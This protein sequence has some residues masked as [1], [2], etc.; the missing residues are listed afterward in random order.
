MEHREAP[1]ARVMIAASILAADLSRLGEEIEAVAEAG[2]DYIHIDVMDGQ[3]VPPITMGQVMVEAAR[4]STSLPLDVHLMVAEPHRQIAPTVS[5]GADMVTVHVE[6]SD[7][8]PRLLDQIKD[9]GARAGVAMNPTTPVDEIEHVLPSADRVL[10]MTV[11]PGYAG[12]R[13]LHHVL[14]KVERIRALLG[15]AGSS[16]ELAVDG[17]VDVDTAPLAVSAGADVLVA[18]TALFKSEKSVEKAFA[19]LRASLVVP[20]AARG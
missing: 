14:P 20:S 11:D 16:V 9:S 3:F 10:A 18:A 12:Q 6:A 15:S 4:R 17:G 7:G 8:L 1:G 5:A 19:Q 2:A 13:F